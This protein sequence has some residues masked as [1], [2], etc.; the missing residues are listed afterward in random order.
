MTRFEEFVLTLK[1]S[2]GIRALPFLAAIAVPSSPLAASLPA[3]PAT[4][5]TQQAEDTARVVTIP[6]PDADSDAAIK[7]D[8]LQDEANLLLKDAF[9]FL[10]GIRT[11]P[12]YA[13]IYAQQLSPTDR[14]ELVKSQLEVDLNKFNA[15]INAKYPDLAVFNDPV[16]KASLGRSPEFSARVERISEMMDGIRDVMSTFRQ[17]TKVGVTRA[18]R[19]AVLEFDIRIAQEKL[20]GVLLTISQRYDGQETKSTISEGPQNRTVSNAFGFKI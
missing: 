19:N 2:Q 3:F 7:I 16:G 10:E 5:I 12:A 20:A 15:D 4:T 17:T 1:S 18:D 14:L 9:Q 6:I 8:R 13:V 11:N